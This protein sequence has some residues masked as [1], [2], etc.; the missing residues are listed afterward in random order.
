MKHL[1]IPAIAL[2]A[3]STPALAEQPSVGQTP[4]TVSA[5]HAR[6][7]GVN[8]K[9]LR[10]DVKARKPR[11]SRA[12]GEIPSI[13]PP[14]PPMTAK[15]AVP[16]DWPAYK[17]VSVLLVRDA[18]SVPTFISEKNDI[19]DNGASLSYTR[20]GIAN[21]QTIAGKGAV[22]YA[23]SQWIPPAGND[24]N[25]V[26]L[27][28]YSLVSGVEWDLKTKNNLHQT[29]GPVSALF[30]SEFLIASP[31][32]P[33]SFLKSN[34]VY[35]TDASDG[36]AQIYGAEFAWQPVAPQFRIGTT[37][38]LSRDLDLWLGF[39][40]TLNADYFHVGN[41]GDFTNLVTGRD[42]LWIGPKVQADLSFHSGILE[43][44]SFFL[45]YFYL[46]DA[47]NGGGQNV[48]YGQVGAKAKLIEWTDP[49]GDPLG[50]LSLLLRYTNGTAV[51]TLQQN[52][53]L[54]AGVTLKFG[55]VPDPSKRAE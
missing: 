11:S 39:Y 41:S 7:D 4:D 37:T 12:K 35:T 25:V 42:Y 27:G 24:P 36:R 17:P 22:F 8:M 49:N 18:Y 32:I 20:N 6:D 50:N 47:L 53:E 40:P 54:Y 38:R 10:D 33:L 44:Y 52:N 31:V 30:G 16:Q 19:S 1:F 29:T 13:L 28:H 48:N 46:Y 23:V 26:G 43:R 34:I 9:R 5:A 15:A 55:N 45:K 2:L 51:R 14:L 21:T 3:V